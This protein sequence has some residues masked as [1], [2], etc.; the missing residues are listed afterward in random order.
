MTFINS[1]L[2][3][4][5]PTPIIPS[6]IARE[7]LE[8][9]LNASEGQLP[10]E[11]LALL[12]AEPANTVNTPNTVTQDDEYIIT[13]YYVIPGTESG[14][15]SAKLQSI[16][17]PVNSRIVGSFHSHPSG[18][19]QPS[20]EDMKLFRKYP[21]N[22]IAGSPFTMESWQAYGPR[23]NPIDLTTITATQTNLSINWQTELQELQKQ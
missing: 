4:I 1:V 13:S 17:V 21:V 22:I 9:C 5:L 2:S 11:F 20:Q 15:V 19:Q 6:Y 7:V 16:N 12:V 8:D 3:W 10:D 23:S 14:P 18:S